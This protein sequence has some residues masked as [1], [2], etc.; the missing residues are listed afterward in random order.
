MWLSRPDLLPCFPAR[1]TGETFPA[2]LARGWKTP[3][4]PRLTRHPVKSRV[5]ACQFRLIFLCG[6]L[7]GGPMVCMN[8]K[9][10][11]AIVVCAAGKWIVLRLSDGMSAGYRTRYCNSRSRQGNADTLGRSQLGRPMKIE[12]SDT[13][14][15]IVG[16]YRGGGWAF[17]LL[18]PPSCWQEASS[19]VACGDGVKHIDRCI[20][21]PLSSFPQESFLLLFFHCC[22]PSHLPRRQTLFSA[23][24]LLPH[25]MS[26]LKS[27]SS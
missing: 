27:F 25:S 6:D 1:K 4:L 22:W 16:G 24:L 14:R 12:S 5:I 8:S 13:W 7:E 21:R 18:E 11:W 17:C 10:A 3:R 19:V 15:E 26:A 23:P 2:D 9:A 20:A